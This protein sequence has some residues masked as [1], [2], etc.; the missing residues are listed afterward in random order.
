[1]W[2]FVGRQ[3][4]DQGFYPWDKKD[5]NWLSGVKPLDEAK[6]YNQDHL[7]D[8]MKN[9]KARNTYYFL[10]LIFGL[11]GMFFHARKDRND[12]LGILAIFVITGIGIIIYSNQPPN[13]PRER[14]YVLVGSF[15]TFCIWIGMSVVQLYELVKN[16]GWLK[17]KTGALVMTALVLTAP[18]I[19]GFENF[20]DHSRRHHYAARDYAANFLNS[21]EENA[22]LFTYGDN[23]TY[24]LWYAQEVEGIRPDVRVV[25]LS[26]IAVDWYIEQ[27]RRKVNESPAIKMSIPQESYRG[28][29][30]NSVLYFNK[31]QQD[32]DMPLLSAVKFIGES[33]PV[34]GGSGQTYESYLPSRKLYIPVD[35]NAAVRNEM[36]YPTDTNVVDRIPIDLTDRQY[37][38]KDE[39]AVL[40]IIASNIWD[41]PI[42]F[43]VTCQESKL[44]GLQNFMQLE[45]LGLRIV[46]IKSRSDKNYY[47]YGSGRVDTKRTYETIVNEWKW[48][49]FDK[50]DLYV[51]T[52]YMPAVQAMRMIM[53]RT[54]QVMIQ[55]GQQDKA[56]EIVDKYFEGFPN[57]NFPYNATTVPIIGVY[58]Q[59]GEMEKL[60]T[61]LGILAENTRQE[62][63]FLQSIDPQIVQ[64]SFRSEQAFA[65]QAA[66]D[67]IQMARST[68]DNAFMTEVENKLSGF[69]SERLRN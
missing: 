30:R 19:M 32:R 51:N 62:L 34:Q 3:N 36:I 63:E 13:E 29:K 6:L 67:C 52:S 33:H 4:G 48:G 18:I 11:I 66:R 1:M 16:K 50:M 54:S 64:S 24:P 8:A 44:Q 37:I 55:D 25:N 12:F 27:A 39:L 53:M 46:P 57:M 59:A 35:I 61:H 58:E 45:G 60:K 49:N 9:D 26:L 68:Q 17:P 22:I 69:I 42:Y 15:F 47:I 40:D 23:D 56:V 14:D 38:T 5:G 10:P 7:T 28:S 43:S 31:N 41:R 20:D 2:N 21:V 65:N